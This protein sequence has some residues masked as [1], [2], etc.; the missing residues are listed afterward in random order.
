MT[1]KPYPSKPDSSKA[2]LSKSDSS[3][4]DLGKPLRGV[5]FFVHPPGAVNL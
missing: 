3:K 5:C 4:F 1:S 2:D